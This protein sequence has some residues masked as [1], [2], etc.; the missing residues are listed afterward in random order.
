[1]NPDRY[2]NLT[3][4]QR[5]R[6]TVFR[7]DQR[8]GVREPHVAPVNALVDELI[9][10]QR[11]TSGQAWMPYVAPL[12]GGVHARVLSIF[13]DPGPA[14][15]RDSG[16][17]LLCVENDDD[18]ARRMA[19]LLEDVG[20]PY[21]EFLPW[22]GYPWYRHTVGKSKPPTPAQCAAGA[23]VLPRLLALAQNVRIV[24]LHGDTAQD[25]WRRYR[26]AHWRQ[27]RRFHVVETCHTGNRAFIAPPK[28]RD[29]R[30]RRLY[31]RFAEVAEI[32][33]GDDADDRAR[34]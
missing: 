27:A 29:E 21:S 16:S 5:M 4:Y 30:L 1:M 10:E 6:S 24:M 22:N 26:D 13:Q 25:V 7:A 18:S 2:R 15:R 12:S 32:L 34:A 14:T 9:A 3:R 28:V 20:L 33:R 11:A 8:R 23:E 17:G 31:D 19:T